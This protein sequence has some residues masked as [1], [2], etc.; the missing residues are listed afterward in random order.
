[1]D[2]IDER[3]CGRDVP[4][5]RVV[6]CLL[7][8]HSGGEP[9]R[10]IRPCGT[11][12]A[13]LRT[14]GDWL[15]EAGCSPVALASTGVSGKPIGNLLED[16]CSLLLVTPRDSKAVPGRKTDITDAEW[17]ADLL[18]H[19]LLRGRDVPDQPQREVR[20]LTRDR[21]S[22]VRERTAEAN[23]LRTGAGAGRAGRPAPTLHGRRAPRAHRLPGGGH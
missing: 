16:A 5:Q 9:T 22:L 17:I 13:D 14:L 19:G 11:L 6:A 2:V 18:R 12:T 4:K 8:A 3:W 7:I 1:M 15:T 10:T 21:T 20:E 23:R